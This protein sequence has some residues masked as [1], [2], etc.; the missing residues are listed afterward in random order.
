MTCDRDEVGTRIV[1]YCYFFLLAVEQVLKHFYARFIKEIDAKAIMYDLE[2]EKIIG[3]N[4]VTTISQSNSPRQNSQFLHGHL[5]RTCDK[6]SFMTVCDIIIAVEG[7]P[8]MN[9]LGEAMKT[10]LAS[11]LHVQV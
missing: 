8:R 11:E 5:R 6:D 1:N 4:E 3:A 2:H 10:K 9:N 7:N